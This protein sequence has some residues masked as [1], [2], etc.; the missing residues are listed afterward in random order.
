MTNPSSRARLRRS[1]V[2]TRRLG[3]AL[4]YPRLSVGI[5]AAFLLGCLLEVPSLASALL[6]PSVYGFQCGLC[7][8]AG[9]RIPCCR[10]AWQLPSTRSDYGRSNDTT[11]TTTTTMDQ[12]SPSPRIKCNDELSHT[13]MSQS[14]A[15]LPLLDVTV[16][17]FDQ[18]LLNS[19]RA[20]EAAELMTREAVQ[21]L[22]QLVADFTKSYTKAPGQARDRK[23]QDLSVEALVVCSKIQMGR[24]RYQ[25]YHHQQ[26]SQEQ[27]AFVRDMQCQLESCWTDLTSLE[28]Y[29][30]PRSSAGTAAAANDSVIPTA[31]ERA[32]DLVLHFGRELCDTI[33][34]NESVL[35]I[36]ARSAINTTS[37]NE[38][39]PSIV[40]APFTMEDK[41]RSKS[42]QRS[43]VET[44]EKTSAT[45]MRP[46]FDTMTK[47][48]VYDWVHDSVM[49][50]SDT[51]TTNDKFDDS[52]IGTGARNQSA[53][54]N[55]RVRSSPRSTI[56]STASRIRKNSRAKGQAV[57]PIWS[58]LGIKPRSPAKMP[59]SR[60]TP[61]SSTRVDTSSNTP[62]VRWSSLV[63]NL[64]TV[65]TT[66]VSKK[67]PFANTDA[68]EGDAV[69]D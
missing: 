59:P 48:E 14:L 52:S 9:W 33:K 45:R 69:G 43:L 58:K 39:V 60:T 3:R 55:A 44:N 17:D 34:E 57:S 56:S 24:T 25:T 18:E 49:A 5:P 64:Y 21:E 53:G 62:V 54:E 8:A 6:S 26:T 68:T 42:N 47:E 23:L 46:E 50:W 36:P 2:P 40:D 35:D 16:D 61:I 32:L 19:T 4:V 67:L 13:E 65:P 63:H 37:F 51:N 29:T 38:T 22:T 30:K 10:A 15:D 27:S 41:K 31:R 11:T 66:V 1:R 7:G 12:D 20:A 28:K